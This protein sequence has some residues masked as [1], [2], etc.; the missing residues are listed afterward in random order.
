MLPFPVHSKTPSRTNARSSGCLSSHSTGQNTQEA[1][2]YG[3]H[4]NNLKREKFLQENDR[5]EA[6]TP[7]RLPPNSSVP[8]IA[9][10]I[11]QVNFDFP[12]FST[13]S[14]H[15]IFI[16]QNNWKS[17]IEY[18]SSDELYLIPDSDFLI[19]TCNGVHSFFCKNKITKCKSMLNR[20]TFWKRLL[21]FEKVKSHWQLV[22]WIFP[23][24]RSF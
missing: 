23:F 15:F 18:I 9:A 24:R 1:K 22:K 20:N 16:C 8:N 4:W 10:S 12:F 3:K 19:S 2:D 11:D 7:N 13:L 5:G 21:F 17:H 6:P 14:L